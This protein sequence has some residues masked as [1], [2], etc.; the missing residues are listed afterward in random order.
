LRR[1]LIALVVC[2][3]TFPAVAA[4]QDDTTGTNGA[5]LIILDASGSMA[6]LDED[7]VPF[8][9]RAKAAVLRLVD[10]LPDD[11]AVGLRVYGHREPNTDPVRGC[12]DTELVAP[13]EL[14]DRDAIRR[15]VLGLEASGFTPIG[16]SLQEAANDLPS[17]GPRTIVLISDGED[18]CAPPDPCTIADELYGQRI[19][20]RVE[21]IGFLIDGG[22]L[23]ERQLRCIADVSGGTYRTVDSTEGLA[24]TLNEVATSL[25]EWRPPMVLDGALDR[26][27][28]PAVPL[29]PNLNWVNDEPGKLGLGRF[30][31][32][33]MPGETRWYRIDLW[34]WEDLWVWADLAWP[35]DTDALGAFEVVIIDP[36]GE[37]VEQPAGEGTTTRIGLPSFASPMIGAG[38]RS[39][40]MG[41][42]PSGTYFVGLRWDAPEATTFG[43]VNLSFEVL[44]DAPRYLR[45]TLL[46]GAFEPADAPV[47]PLSS[48]PEN[49]PAWMGGEFRGPIAPGETRWYRLEMEPAEV[50]NVSALFPG[51]RVVGAGADGGFA[52][53]IT[54]LDGNPV[55]G[56]FGEWPQMS[57]AFGGAPR[58]ARV[59]GTTSSTPDPLPEVV[60][61][62]FTWDGSASRESEIRF[63][64][65]T[66]LDEGREGAHDEEPAVEEPTDSTTSSVTPAPSTTV[67][68]ATSAAPAEAQ[69]GSDDGDGPPIA[70]FIAIGAAVITAGAIGLLARKRR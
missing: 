26:M 21:T 18:T 12:R 69:P 61:I 1:L 20:V 60:L 41:Y 62:G 46:E 47:L 68:A 4:A 39:P 38:I 27:L 50:M 30:T 35:A 53:E 55:G 52:V 36:D 13:V 31:G 37:R 6:T 23:A 32:L 10:A 5:L 22:S 59:G 7:G 15:A 49:G 63:G 16:L 17:S 14:L 2:V 11:L 54:D 28:A 51:D 33:L 66:M 34:E 65:E 64:V 3:L 24:G 43:A 56:P 45:R 8:I 40:D 44:G 58:Q 42:I 25:V 57:Q 9:E 67:A 19:D 29:V 48:V 70:L